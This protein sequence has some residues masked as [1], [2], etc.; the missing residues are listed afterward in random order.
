[1][2]GRM[3]SINIWFFLAFFFQQLLWNTRMRLIGFKKFPWP[4]CVATTQRWCQVAVMILLFR[5]LAKGHNGQRQLQFHLDGSSSPG[6]LGHLGHGRAQLEKMT[7]VEGGWHFVSGFLGSVEYK[8]S[9]NFL[10]IP[11]PFQPK[12][13][14]LLS[15]TAT[16][17]LQEH[18]LTY[19]LIMYLWSIHHG[20]IDLASLT[21]H[22]SAQL[23]MRSSVR[24]R[25]RPCVWTQ[26]GFLL[27]R[28]TPNEQLKTSLCFWSYLAPRA[29]SVM[30]AFV[31]QIVAVACLVQR[32]A[33][34]LWLG[35]FQLIRVMDDSATGPI[36]LSLF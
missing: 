3:V 6:A 32:V 5:R 36:P 22:S 1:M 15:F 16:H 9:A 25:G 19:W 18:A 27:L 12:Q 14:L 7:S 28:P 29:I 24:T 11:L 34:L 13:I 23:I 31:E 2:E 4:C 8:W 21:S 26:L 17:F 10:Q 35:G 20:Q 30:N 33:V